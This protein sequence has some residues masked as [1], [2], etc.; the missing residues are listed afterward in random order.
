MRRQPFARPRNRAD[1]GAVAGQ[2]TEGNKH[3]RVAFRFKVPAL[4]NAAF[5]Q[6][7]L[8]IFETINKVTFIG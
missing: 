3:N 8:L 4:L 5:A 6:G 2:A 1:K 7:S